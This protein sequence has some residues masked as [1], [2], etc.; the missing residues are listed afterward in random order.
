MESVFCHNK[1]NQREK[2]SLEISDDLSI[3]IVL[4]VFLTFH[5]EWH[6]P[7]L[8]SETCL[9]YSQRSFAP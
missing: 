5:G 2:V 1:K 4:W 9:A 3:I 8:V 7:Q 6:R